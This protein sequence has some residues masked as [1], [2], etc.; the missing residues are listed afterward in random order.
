[1]HAGFHRPNGKKDINSSKR[2]NA[3]YIIIVMVKKIMNELQLL[4][5][6]EDNN[7]WLQ[8][9]FDEVQEKYG[10]RFVAVVDKN[11]KTAGENSKIVI[12]N[13]KKTGIDPV[14]AIIMWIPKKG[15]III[16]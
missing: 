5:E 8:A 3:V 9:H 12:E 15:Q 14:K 6:M 7:Q 13:L 16:L 10:E 2:L 4:T 11:V 1:M